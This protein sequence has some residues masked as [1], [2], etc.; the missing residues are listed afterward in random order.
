M[1]ALF[2][3][4]AIIIRRKSGKKKKKAK[5]YQKKKYF[6]G[7]TL[8]QEMFAMTDADEVGMGDLTY[9]CSAEF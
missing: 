9:K 4:S 5:G 6:V 2:L 1:A 8:T 3:P 7:Q